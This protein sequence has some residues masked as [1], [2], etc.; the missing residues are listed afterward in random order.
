ML[1][2]SPNAHPV[3]KEKIFL[4]AVAL[5]ILGEAYME[6]KK[7]GSDELGEGYVKVDVRR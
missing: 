2:D 1:R 7:D 5:E 6:V 4:R 3:T